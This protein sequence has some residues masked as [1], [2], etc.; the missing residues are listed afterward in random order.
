MSQNIT[1]QI[2][3]KINGFWSVIA[4]PNGHVVKFKSL[5]RRT[6]QDFADEFNAACN[7]PAHDKLNATVGHAVWSARTSNEV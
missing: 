2:V 7:V 1:K 4:D 3:K 5:S 6:A